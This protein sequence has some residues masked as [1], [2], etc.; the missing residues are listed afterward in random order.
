MDITREFLLISLI[1]L[2]IIFVRFNNKI[3]MIVILS[4]NIIIICTSMLIWVQMNIY[5]TLPVE[6]IRYQLA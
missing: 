2:I 3:L 4:I 5:E 1:I 6:L